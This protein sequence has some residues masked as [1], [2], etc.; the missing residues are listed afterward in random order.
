MAKIVTGEQYYQLDGQLSEIKRQLRQPAGYP[1]D[2]V[3]L[4][5]GLQR[6]IEGKLEIPVGV[7]MSN[8]VIPTMFKTSD[9]DLDWWLKR[10]ETFARKR[11]G[12]KVSLREMFDVPTELPWKSVIPVFDPGGLTNRD[13]VD[14][15]L[16]AQNLTVYEETDVMGYTGSEANTKPTLILIKNSIRPDEDTL[17]QTG[18][19]ADDLRQT[20]KPY[21]RLR[22]Y[23]LAMGL[24]YFVKKGYLDPKETW[25]RFPEDRLP[26]GVVALGRWFPLRR[27]VGFGW[28]RPGLRRSRGGGRVAMSVSLKS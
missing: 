15:A 7:V 4:S 18:M 14:K 3:K 5:E 27:R 6:L 11:L 22:G 28:G 2:P 20:G 12:V 25:T 9:T 26:G 13:M 23:G 21:L 16:K 24:Y 8:W 17:T 19:S 10:A 1:Y